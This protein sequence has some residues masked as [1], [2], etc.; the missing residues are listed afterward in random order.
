MDR[1]AMPP[2]GSS[3]WFK[4]ADSWQLC[5][6]DTLFASWSIPVDGRAADLSRPFVDTPYSLFY[7]LQ[8]RVQ[9]S[10]VTYQLGTNSEPTA[11]TVGLAPEQLVPASHQLLLPHRSPGLP[12]AGAQP[13]ARL[14]GTAASGFEL[15]DRRERCRLVASLSG[16]QHPAPSGQRIDILGSRVTLWF[17]EHPGTSLRRVETSQP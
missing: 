2:D 1:M 17:P 7:V 11:W 3:A 5:D 6:G 10:T 8:F 9:A 4:H 12:V 13:I 15:Y 16:T 14:A